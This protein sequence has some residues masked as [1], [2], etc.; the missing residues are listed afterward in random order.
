MAALRRKK[1]H[2]A[3]LEETVENIKI[4]EGH[5]KSMESAVAGMPTA[6]TVTKTPPAPATVCESRC[7]QAVLDPDALETIMCG[8]APWLDE[9]EKEALQLLKDEIELLEQEQQDV[10]IAKADST[11]GVEDAVDRMTL[12]E[13]HR[14]PSQPKF[15]TP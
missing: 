10:P 2:E 3:A 15:A 12:S 6:P 5:I 11:V 4:L 7:R 14:G 8:A 1:R 13:E 9:E